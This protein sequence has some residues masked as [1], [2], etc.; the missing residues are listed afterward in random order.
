RAL[1]ILNQRPA[2]RIQ[3]DN[4]LQ[5]FNCISETSSEHDQVR[6]DSFAIYKLD[7]TILIAT[8]TGHSLDQALANSASDCSP[9][10]RLGQ[11]VRTPAE[12]T[13]RNLLGQPREVVNIDA[14]DPMRHRDESRAQRQ[15]RTILF[16]SYS[17][18]IL[19]HFG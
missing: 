7:F 8:H 19:E 9:G 17:Q 11:P 15:P 12:Q 6:F 14:K 1:T 16:L 4:F 13:R 10:H 18:P 5:V 2:I 3:I